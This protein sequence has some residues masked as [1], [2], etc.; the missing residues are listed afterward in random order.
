MNAPQSKTAN[1]V[2]GALL[3]LGITASAVWLI[4]SALTSPVNYGRLTAGLLVL[5]LALILLRGLKDQLW[6]FQQTGP[7]YRRRRAYRRLPFSILLSIAP[8]AILLWYG[9]FAPAVPS[10][11]RGG[12]DVCELQVGLC[13]SGTRAFIFWGIVV[14]IGGLIWAYVLIRSAGKEG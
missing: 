11:T 7:E 13:V 9:I 10:R 12:I 2:T 6:S 4:L 1:R 3:K 5:W 14:L 8:G